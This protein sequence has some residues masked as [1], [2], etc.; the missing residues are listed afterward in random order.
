MAAASTAP[1][2]QQPSSPVVTVSLTRSSY[3]DLYLEH[4]FCDAVLR[5]VGLAEGEEDPPPPQLFHVHRAVLCPASH[6]FDAFF[7]H[8]HQHQQPANEEGPQRKRRRT[9]SE[10]AVSSGG[11]EQLHDDVETRQ[12]TGCSGSSPALPEYTLT[13]QEDVSIS[14]CC[15]TCTTAPP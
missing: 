2:Q 3:S 9:V 13:L 4:R 15:S 10:T 14:S 1:Q 5:V 6:F 8:Q 11:P 7:T 12:G